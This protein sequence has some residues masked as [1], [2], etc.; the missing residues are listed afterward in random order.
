MK[1]ENSI[2]NNYVNI[3]GEIC[4][5]FTFSYEEHGEKFYMVHLQTKRLSSQVDVIPLM[6]SNLLIDVT[7]NYEGCTVE[8]TGQFRSYNKEDGVRTRLML[9]VFAKGINFLDEFTDYA[10]AN[11][12]YLAG[13][14]CKEPIYRIT[15]LGV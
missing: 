2:S 9:F 7:R 6:V 4:S 5:K 15:P 14:I 1:R 11:Q 12:I 13:H 8:A 10:K 3:I